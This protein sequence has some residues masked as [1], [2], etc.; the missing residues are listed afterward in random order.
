MLTR[1]LSTQLLS[2]SSPSS[3]L[4]STSN[5]KF[6]QTVP[7]YSV[8]SQRKMG[9]LGKIDPSS[10]SQPELITTQHSVLSWKVDFE[11]TKL[12]GTVTHRFKVLEKDLPAIVSN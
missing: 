8:Q 2:T 7:L 12:K 1:T 10:Y 3:A 9:R 11:N 6:Q 5:R 4:A